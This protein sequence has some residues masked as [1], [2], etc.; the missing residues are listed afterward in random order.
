VTAYLSDHPYASAVELAE[1]RVAE[2][3]KDPHTVPYFDLTISAVKTVFVLHAPT[4]SQPAR[5]QARRRGPGRSA[6]RARL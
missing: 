3:G 5:P 1:V 2:R 4:G 6:G